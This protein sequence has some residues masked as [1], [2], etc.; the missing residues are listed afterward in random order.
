MTISMKFYLTNSTAFVT[1]RH[2]GRER[3]HEFSTVTSSAQYHWVF[4][5]AIQIFFSYLFSLQHKKISVM[6]KAHN[7]L[8][9]K[10]L[11]K[12][13]KNLTMIIGS[14]GRRNGT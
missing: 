3:A 13:K 12:G 5:I 6:C 7:W 9:S 8:N 2:M 14:H 4:F 1:T 10:S 11:I